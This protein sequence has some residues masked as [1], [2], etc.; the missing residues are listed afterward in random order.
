MMSA[1]VPARQSGQEQP[2]GAAAVQA[3][4]EIELV[5]ANISTIVDPLAG[6]SSPA[7]SQTSPVLL[8]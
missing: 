5:A 3:S 6:A 7:H 2:P 8:R 1:P 4:A